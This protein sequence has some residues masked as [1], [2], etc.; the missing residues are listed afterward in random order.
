MG[1]GWYLRST[2]VWNYDFD[3]TAFAVPLGLG[4]GKVVPTGNT[5][6]NVFVEP[7]YSVLRQGPGQME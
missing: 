5:L 7:Q 2:G 1:E 3:N 4:I 6:A